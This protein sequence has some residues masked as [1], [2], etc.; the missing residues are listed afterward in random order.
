[1]EIRTGMNRPIIATAGTRFRGRVAIGGMGGAEAAASG[2]AIDEG[3][4][5]EGV[6]TASHVFGK[7]EFTMTHPALFA[8]SS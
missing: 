8:G 3:L 5:E 7:L 6:V 4:A 2:I 1:M